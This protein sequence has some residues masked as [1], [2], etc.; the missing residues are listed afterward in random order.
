MI[1]SYFS[2]MSQKKEIFNDLTRALDVMRIVD[3]KTPKNI[4]FYAMWLLETRQL[5][6]STALNVS[7]DCFVSIVQLTDLYL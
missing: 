5:R 2:V 6:N 7:S 1:T 4:V 3:E